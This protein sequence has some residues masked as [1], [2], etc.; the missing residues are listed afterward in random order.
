MW[1]AERQVTVTVWESERRFCVPVALALQHGMP[2]KQEQEAAQSEVVEVAPDVLRM[3]LPIEMFGLGHVN[4]YAF[5]DAK[6]LAVM[7]PGLPGDAQWEVICERL[8]Q[9]G[10]A[11]RHVHTVVITHSHPDHFGG[12]ARFRLEAGA[13]VIGHRSFNAF[14]VALG[15]PH[16]EVSV[17]YHQPEPVAEPS[18]E[19]A[20]VPWFMKPEAEAPPTPWGGRPMSLGPGERERWQGLFSRGVAIPTLTHSVRHGS[21]I[22]L[23]GRPWSVWH[24]PGHTADHVCLHDRESGTFLS[25]DHVLPSITPHISGLSKHP[26]PLQAFYDSL[27]RV[28]EVTPAQVCLPAHG[29]PFGDLS[30]RVAAIKR[31]HDERLDKLVAIGKR[32]GP[33]TVEQFAQELF[34]P[35][36]W[37]PMAE[38]EA[39][40][41]LEHVRLQKRAERREHPD[42]RSI[43]EM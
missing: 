28:L 34:P 6:G 31:H 13:K 20:P 1:H 9:A 23:A 24:T 8:K 7:D 42:G 39:Y 4:M 14:G 10:Y 21:V 26:S 38:S 15:E 29:H 2:G 40:A 12:A 36:S 19:D 35:R 11:V 17:E 27:D 18:S 37:G 30:G 25:G 22:E 16:H 43:Y 41:H 5:R 32:I 3:Q 33:A